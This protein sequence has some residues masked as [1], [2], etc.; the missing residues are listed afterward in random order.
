M[1]SWCLAGRSALPDT[2]DRQAAKIRRCASLLPTSVIDCYPCIWVTA[3]TPLKVASVAIPQRQF[4][5]VHSVP[6]RSARSRVTALRVKAVSTSRDKTEV[7]SGD[8]LCG[9]G[10]PVP[11]LAA[12]SRVNTTKASTLVITK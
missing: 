7:L 9:A 3:V 2:A 4:R 5:T 6:G 12:H 11:R 1:R 10:T 8:D